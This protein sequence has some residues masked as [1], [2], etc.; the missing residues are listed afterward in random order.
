MMIALVMRR[1]V[2]VYVKS[3]DVHVYAHGT[4]HQDGMTIDDIKREILNPIIEHLKKE[5]GKIKMTRQEAIFKYKTAT[6]KSNSEVRVDLLGLEALGLIKFDE[7]KTHTLYEAQTIVG[8][9]VR[10]EKWPEGM[11]LWYNGEIVWK[12]WN[13]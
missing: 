6:G 9:I 2:R 4:P 5:E 11:V 10:L 1:T 7:P 3:F 8:G 13:A 12:S